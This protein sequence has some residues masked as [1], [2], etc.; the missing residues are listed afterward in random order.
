MHTHTRR[1]FIFSYKPFCEWVFCS[2]NSH[3]HIPSLSLSLFY[4]HMLIA[5]SDSIAAFNLLKDVSLSCFSP[6]STFIRGRGTFT[7]AAYK[8]T[9]KCDFPAFRVGIRALLLLSD[10]FMNKSQHLV[11]CNKHFRASLLPTIPHL[12]GGFHFI[13]R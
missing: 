9:K 8:N 3:C 10:A 6:S 13:P 12:L 4:F 11:K 1:P 7:G 5:G 2:I